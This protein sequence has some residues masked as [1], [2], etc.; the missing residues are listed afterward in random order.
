MMRDGRGRRFF[1]LIEPVNGLR[2]KPATDR[3]RALATP[4]S[5]PD[6]VAPGGRGD[7]S[8][9]LSGGLARLQRISKRCETATSANRAAPSATPS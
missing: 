7:L 3:A 9:A 6:R 5:R 2:T 4:R 1:K 8:F